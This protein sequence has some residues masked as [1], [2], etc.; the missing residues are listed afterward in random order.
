MEDVFE[1]N[2]LNVNH[3]SGFG[4]RLIVRP[5]VVEFLGNI[6]FR[7]MVQNKPILIW[8][9][10]VYLIVYYSFKWT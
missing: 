1:Q 5:V 7:G 2:F 10:V 4:S 9:Y 3:M 8:H 6:Q